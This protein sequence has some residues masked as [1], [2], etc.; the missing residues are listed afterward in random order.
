[1]LPKLPVASTFVYVL[2]IFVNSV[3]LC[4]NQICFCSLQTFCNLPTPATILFRCVCPVNSS[5]LI[6]SKM[7]SIVFNQS[8]PICNLHW[9]YN[10]ALVLPK[11]C[12][13]FLTNQNQVIFVCILLNVFNLLSDFLDLT[14]HKLTTFV[15]PCVKT[16]HVFIAFLQ[17][18]Y[19]YD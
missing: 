13:P 1:M 17:C 18:R 11:S 2:V 15:L 5:N 3:K 7:A 6:G 4:M 10:F 12:T 19:R 8:E 14:C 16:L 9:C